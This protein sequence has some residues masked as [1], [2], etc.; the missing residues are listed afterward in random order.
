MAA[1]EHPLVNCLKKLGSGAKI[2]GR[3]GN[4]KHAIFLLEVSSRP[5]PDV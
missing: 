5:V 4:L 1:W 2:K 3:S